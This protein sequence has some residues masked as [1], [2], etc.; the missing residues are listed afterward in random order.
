MITELRA[1]TPQA[2]LP[3][4]LINSNMCADVFSDRHT[5]TKL[6]EC[7]PS[8]SCNDVSAMW[9][10]LKEAS[11]VVLYPVRIRCLKSPSNCS[12]KAAMKGRQTAEEK[13]GSERGFTDSRGA[14]T[15]RAFPSTNDLSKPE[16]LRRH[17]VCRGYSHQEKERERLRA[18]L[19][20]HRRLRKYRHRSNGKKDIRNP[21]EARGSINVL[22]NNAHP[23]T[24]E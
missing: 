16:P 7:L 24:G 20:I 11:A 22:K 6:R 4:T 3:H 17:S 23:K 9:K 2:C 5:R 19:K 1:D 12:P 15:T 10:R 13:D 8:V 14:R 18:T 21:N